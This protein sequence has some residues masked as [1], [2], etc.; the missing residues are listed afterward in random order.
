MNLSGLY[1]SLNNGLIHRRRVSNASAS[2]KRSSLQ[3]HRPSPLRHRKKG[4]GYKRRA[5][6]S[7]AELRPTPFFFV[8]EVAS[9]VLTGRDNLFGG[10]IQPRIP[11]DLSSTYVAYAPARCASIR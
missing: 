3:R 10:L 11:P 2:P 9:L 7:Q 4:C 6:R 5:T 1:A 8:N